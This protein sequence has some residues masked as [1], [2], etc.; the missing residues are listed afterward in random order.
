MELEF[1]Q[2]VFEKMLEYQ[3]SWKSVQL[4]QSCFIRT[5]VQT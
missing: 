1:S 5:D 2:Q 3:I 4:E